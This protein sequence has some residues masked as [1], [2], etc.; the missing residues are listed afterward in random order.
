MNCA[1]LCATG[2]VARNRDNSSA[3]GEPGA[4]SRARARGGYRLETAILQKLIL[5]PAQ[6]RGDHGDAGK[7]Q[8]FIFEHL[9]ITGNSS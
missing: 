9:S 3:L 4:P 2:T 1:E 8:V 5:A 6:A 7:C